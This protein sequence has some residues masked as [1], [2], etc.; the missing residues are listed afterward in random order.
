MCRGT[1]I[2]RRFGKTTKLITPD[3][4]ITSRRTMRCIKESNLH[5][6]NIGSAIQH[7]SGLFSSQ[8]QAT[9]CDQDPLLL[10]NNNAYL[11]GRGPFRDSCFELHRS[12]AHHILH[13]NMNKVLKKSFDDAGFMNKLEPSEMYREDKN[14]P[15][16]MMPYGVM[17]K[18]TVFM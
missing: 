16:G 13:V 6:K 9:S 8:Y 10:M 3:F 11:V 12:E 2:I 4:R 14:I 18:R 5:S 1:S 7:H 15:D 17:A